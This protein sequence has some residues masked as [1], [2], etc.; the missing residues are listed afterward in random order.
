MSLLTA[1]YIGSVLLAA[2]YIIWSV[3]AFIELRLF[4]RVKRGWRWET[5]EKELHWFS[6]WIFFNGGLLFGALIVGCF[7]LFGWR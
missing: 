4:V 3:K 1:S 2:S 6:S 7:A 5:L